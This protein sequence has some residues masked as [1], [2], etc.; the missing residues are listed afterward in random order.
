[1]PFVIPSLFKRELCNYAAATAPATTIAAGEAEEATK[2]NDQWKW[3]QTIE[4]RLEL[5]AGNWGRSPDSR[6]NRIFINVNR[7]WK[8]ENRKKWKNYGKCKNS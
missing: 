4:L 7:K 8:Q 5:R 6:L 2:R 3:S 1:M